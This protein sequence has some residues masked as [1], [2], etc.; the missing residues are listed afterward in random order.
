[1]PPMPQQQPQDASQ[2]NTQ[3]L[4][5]GMDCQQNPNTPVCQTCAANPTTPAC[6]AL[7]GGE[8]KPGDEAKFEEAA[9]QEV[10][11]FN[12]DDSAS[13]TPSDFP[14]PKIEPQSVKNGTIAN[15]SGGAIPGAG[16]GGG[17]GAQM[18]NAAGGRASPGSPGYTTDIFQ[19][20]MPGGYSQSIG[21]AGT[22]GG[23]GG[24][25]GYGS[26]DGRQIASN[27]TGV[28]LSKF[29]PG[30]EKDP[31]RPRALAGMNPMSAQINGRHVNI[32]EKISIK[33]QEKCHIGKLFDCR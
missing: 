22:D 5:G 1:M 13:M 15:N 6:I 11:K 25:S 10:P 26:G 16:G 18:A 21:N 2:A 3:A 14:M 31:L 8:K 29:L 24:F 9:K 33:F 12:L 23:A 7:N 32:W 4:N 19:G 20:N 28:D 27:D 30:G 17:P